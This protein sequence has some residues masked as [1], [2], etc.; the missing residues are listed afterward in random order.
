[1]ARKSSDFMSL[2]AHRGAARG[3]RPGFWQQFTGSLRAILPRRPDLH[4]GRGARRGGMP[5]AVAAFACLLA[6]YLLGNFLPLPLGG[7]GSGLK[8]DGSR[9]DGV[10]PGVIGDEDL[11]PLTGTCLLTAYYPEPGPAAAAAHQLQEHGL[12]RARPYRFAQEGKAPLWC[13]VVYYD[14]ARER[15]EAK[16]TLREVPAPDARFESF[17]KT[18]KDWP[19]EKQVQ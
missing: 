17:R 10:A 16:A 7:A 5:V 1:V 15:D 3:S 18:Q 19:P 8:A 11:K 2:L 12:K 13:L 4:L 6:G 14:G 9:R